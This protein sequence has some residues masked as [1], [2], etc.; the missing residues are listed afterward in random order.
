MFRALDKNQDGLIDGADV[1]EW[2]VQALG[3]GGCYSLSDT[4]ALVEDLAEDKAG[5]RDARE[6]EGFIDERF[7]GVV[8]YSGEVM[9]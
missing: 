7:D 5:F 1:H 3:M 8:D 4:N 2:L 6:L 9:R